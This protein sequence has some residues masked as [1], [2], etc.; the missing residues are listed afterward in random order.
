MTKNQM[1]EAKFSQML[2]TNSGCYRSN[3]AS[4]S[5]ALENAP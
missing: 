4:P 2:A 1:A 5:T 3:L